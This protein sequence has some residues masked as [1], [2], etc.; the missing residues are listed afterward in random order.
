MSSVR[1]F[2]FEVLPDLRGVMHSVRHDTRVKSFIPGRRYLLQGSSV[3]Q[4]ASVGY[5]DFCV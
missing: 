5:G 4:S 2:R 1:G 3:V